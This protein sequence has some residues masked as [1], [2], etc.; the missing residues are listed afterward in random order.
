MK[1][2]SFELHP[3]ETV[4]PGIEIVLICEGAGATTDVELVLIRDGA[5]ANSLFV[6][7]FSDKEAEEKIGN[8]LVELLTD[9]CLFDEDD[10]MTKFRKKARCLIEGLSTTVVKLKDG[11]TEIKALIDN[12]GDCEDEDK[13]F[14]KLLFFGLLEGC[15]CFLTINVSASPYLGP[16]EHNLHNALHAGEVKLAFVS[17]SAICKAVRTYF[18]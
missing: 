11:S 14:F 2:E 9:D 4:K 3:E 5:G 18:M 16:N 8:E 10:A 7:Q 6:K 17:R 12:T 1:P 13:D 15:F